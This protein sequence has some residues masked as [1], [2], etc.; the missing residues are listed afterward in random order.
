MRAV[1]ISY[2]GFT[3]ECKDSLVG[4]SEER[5]ILLE[6]YDLRSVLECD[7]AL[8]VLLHD[9]QAYLVKYNK[10]YVSA[11]EIINLRRRS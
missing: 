3:Q 11:I 10:P 9:I 2:N 1:F 5:V 4:K 8:D 6:G 7:I